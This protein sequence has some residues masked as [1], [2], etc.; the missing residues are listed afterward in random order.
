MGFLNRI[1]RHAA[2]PPGTR[3]HWF[4]ARTAARLGISL[5]RDE[6]YLQSF[7]CFYDHE[8]GELLEPE[9]AKSV[10]AGWQTNV[11]QTYLER[12]PTASQLSRKLYADIKSTLVSEML[13]KVDR[14]TMAFGLEARVPFLDHQLV[15]WG[16]G[17]ADD[18]KI[19]GTEGKLVVKKALEPLLPQEV[20]YRSKHGFNVPMRIWLRGELRDMVHDLLSPDRVR[21]RGLFQPQ[22]VQRLLV[23]NDQGQHDLSNRIFVLMCLELWFRQY[24]DGRA[25][26][27]RG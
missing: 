14:M 9:V 22:A 10:L 8:L 16:F 6:R 11:T 18:L 23:A 27:V 13:T 3:R 4:A 5:E 2:G 26:L 17:L 25:A 12:Y 19:R 15:E 21:S 1:L 24:G 20:L 7:S